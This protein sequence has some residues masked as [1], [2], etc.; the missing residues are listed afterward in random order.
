VFFVLAI[1]SFAV[2]ILHCVNGAL[3]TILSFRGHGKQRLDVLEW[4]EYFMAIA[5]LS[6]QRSKD[7]KTQVLTKNAHL[8]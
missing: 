6:A 3:F 5:F 8:F 2:P 1:V 7:P 4:S